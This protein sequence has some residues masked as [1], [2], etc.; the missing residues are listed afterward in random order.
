MFVMYFDF[1]ADEFYDIGFFIS[2]LC[3][4]VGGDECAKQV[5]EESNFEVGDF[6]FSALIL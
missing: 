5:V 3:M 6:D 2:A 4:A 1:R